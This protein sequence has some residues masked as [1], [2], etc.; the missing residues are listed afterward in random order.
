MRE[1][2]YAFFNFPDERWPLAQAFFRR[3]GRDD[4]ATQ[5]RPPSGYTFRFYDDLAY[6]RFLGE[7]KAQGFG[8]QAV[9]VRRERV[10][11]EHELISAPLLWISINRAPKGEGGPRYGTQYDLSGACDRC[12]CGAVQV[13]PLRL[14]PSDPPAKAAIFETLDG[15]ILVAEHIARA[16]QKE[17]ISGVDLRQAVSS[18]NGIMLPWFQILPGSELPAMDPSTEGV[19]RSDHCPKCACDGY[20]HRPPVVI[21][22][23]ALE[24]ARLPDVLQTLEHFGNSV[25]KE[26]FELSHFATP[27]LIVKPRVYQLF[28]REK[29]RGIRAVPVDV[30]SADEARP[31]SEVLAGLPHA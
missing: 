27:L 23:K 31:T 14:R 29:V 10:Y 28:K 4:L 3:I 25:I 13:S 8:E 22:Y 17:G 18:T 1:K 2:I 26:P 9:Y 5:R 11:T 16:I 7:L 21:R 30:Q 20:F 19:V 24:T 15:E 6:K 12:G